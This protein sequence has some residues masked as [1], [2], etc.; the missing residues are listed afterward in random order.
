MA[1]CVLIPPPF[2][3]LNFCSFVE[4]AGEGRERGVGTRAQMDSFIV[5]A[6][7]LSLDALRGMCFSVIRSLEWQAFAAL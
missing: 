3:I 1:E 5:L 6:S 4:E 2:E 7:A